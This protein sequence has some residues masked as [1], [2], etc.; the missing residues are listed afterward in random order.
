MAIIF[1][2][3]CSVVPGDWVDTGMYDYN[4]FALTTDGISIYANPIP[5]HTASNNRGDL[6]I[7]RYLSPPVTSDFELIADLSLDCTGIIQ[8]RSIGFGIQLLYNKSFDTI[9]KQISMS[10]VRGSWEWDESNE[11]G[12]WED[13]WYW[14]D[15]CYLIIRE[16]DPSIGET[17]L[18]T[19][20]LKT[21]VPA[22]F[23]GVW[24]ISRVGTTWSFFV[25][26]GLIYSTTTGPA[27]EFGFIT[28]GWGASE[29]TDTTWTPPISKI[30]NISMT[31][32]S[33]VTFASEPPIIV[34]PNPIRCSKPMVVL[35]FQT[36]SGETDW[37]L[38]FKIKAYSE[39]LGTTLIS[40]V[41]S[42][43]NPELFEYSTDG[44][45]SWAAF[46]SV[47]LPRNTYGS[48]VRARLE[49]GPRT[50]VW[51]KASVGSEN[52]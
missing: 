30:N 28:C 42:S 39:E 51:L 47:G 34:G 50:Q 52:V 35:Q 32:G 7:G 12:H 13:N 36:P 17:G 25:D 37:L 9:N 49:V 20:Y 2:D 8:S 22:T 26:S 21:V 29:E 41:D 48:S 1:D 44:E 4:L 40:T 33:S 27:T 15:N 14:D 38:H 23:N 16:Y 46:P 18:Q 6:E 45:L 3:D 11:N 10:F 43:L 19:D 31:A 5:L 24:K